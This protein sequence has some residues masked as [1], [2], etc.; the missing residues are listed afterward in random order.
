MVDVLFQA[1]RPFFDVVVGH[2]ACGFLL[3]KWVRR[4][5]KLK[6]AIRGL[7]DALIICLAAPVRPAVAHHIAKHRRLPKQT[8]IEKQPRHG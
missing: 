5:N 2:G 3:R 7:H 6:P 1:R 8:I 4:R